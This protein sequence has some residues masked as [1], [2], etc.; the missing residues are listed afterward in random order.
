MMKE[1]HW[2]HELMNWEHGGTNLENREIQFLSPG[3]KFTS[4][5]KE[6]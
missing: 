4:N 6:Y 5:N 3:M 1:F 2:G